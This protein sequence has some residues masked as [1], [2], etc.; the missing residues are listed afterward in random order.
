MEKLAVPVSNAAV[1]GM[2][3]TEICREVVVCEDGEAAS[4]R[5]PCSTS[6]A[7]RDG[8]ASLWNG[9]REYC[10]ANDA[11]HGVAAWICR[12]SMA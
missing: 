11:F 8:A 9:G 7:H 2:F 10:A 6:R 3:D 12:L 4:R 5:Q 1:L